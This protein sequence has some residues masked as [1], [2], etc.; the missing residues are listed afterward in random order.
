MQTLTT[1]QEA[2]RLLPGVTGVWAV[3]GTLDQYLVATV[4]KRYASAALTLSANTYVDALAGLDL[5]FTRLPDRAGLASVASFSLDI[6]DEEDESATTGTHT[7]SNDEVVVYWQYYTG[8]DAETDLLEIAR[9]VIE[10]DSVDGYTW[11]WQCRDGSK[12]DLRAIPSTL[13]DPTTYP[14]AWTP[15]LPVPECFGN[16]NVAPYS[17]GGD[18]PA[19]APCKFTDWT[20]LKLTS[21]LRKT[22]G[23]AVYQ[24]YPEASA[25]AEVSTVSHV[26]NITTAA[27]PARVLRLRPSRTKTTND[28]SAYAAAMDADTSTS[29]A[30]VSGDN[31]DLWLAG[32]AALGAMTALKVVVLASGVYTLTVKDDATV[33]YGPTSQNGDATVSLTVGDYSDSWDIALLNVEIDGTG[34]ATIGNVYLQIEFDDYLS[35]GAA[36]PLLFQSVTGF[37]DSTANYYDGAVVSSAGTALRNP[38]HQVQAILRAKNLHNLATA[39]VDATRAAEAAAVRTAWHFDWAFPLDE[40]DPE[41]VLEDI[42]VEAGLYIWKKGGQWRVVAR[43][44]NRS[45][46]HFFL[47]RYHCP[48]RGDDVAGPQESALRV[49]PADASQIINEVAVRYAPHPATGT[50]PRVAIASGKYRLTGSCLVD[51]TTA[52]LTDTSATFVTDGV[53]AKSGDKTGEYIYVEGDTTYEVQSVVSET[54][55]TVAAVDGGA[56]SEID[57]STTYYLGPH[58]DAQALV[59][60]RVYKTVSALG[61]ETSMREAG[62]YAAKFIREKS[63]AEAFRD[64]VIEWDATPRN[65]VE[66]PLHHVGAKLEEGD[67]FLLD[68]EGLFSNLRGVDL[69]QIAEA[70]D[71]TETDWTVESGKAGWFRVD[72][73]VYV[74]TGRSTAPECV[75]VTA[76]DVSASTITVSRA[77]LGTEALAHD[78]GDQLVRCIDW[79]WICT[80]LRPPV[81]EEPY[82]RVEAEQMPNDYYPVGRCVATGYPAWTAATVSQRTQAGW[83][84]LRNGRVQETDLDSNISYVG[85]SSGTYTIT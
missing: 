33:K 37:E 69:C 17:A 10:R 30:I 1:A 71:T 41:R 72:D 4:T 43:D 23:G 51:D 22:T 52:T 31:L 84:T 68:D 50:Y 56:V 79:K 40:Q 82:W 26:S 75:Q 46:S 77:Q 73:Y 65:R 25:F 21:S 60:Q 67:V 44:K 61:S 62:G 29:T 32:C 59:S 53:V 48:A 19:L 16:L 45:P 35:F 24:W 57:T 20:A 9:G 76:V 15:G 83:A 36:E 39:H 81:P 27:D 18:V 28:V 58:I 80:G 47:G 8:S 42:G 78:N 14:Y 54:Q 55:V 66:F 74:Q 3:V 6:R 49:V 34:N 5:G 11:R 7:Q 85:E 38:V 63:T 2:Q 13:L 12:K 64:Y 70:I